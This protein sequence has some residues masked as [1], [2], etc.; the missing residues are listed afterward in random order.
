[1]ENTSGGEGPSTDVE[2]WQQECD[3]LRKVTGWGLGGRK[4]GVLR[5]KH[6]F[7]VWGHLGFTAECFYFLR[8]YSCVLRVHLSYPSLGQADF[9]HLEYRQKT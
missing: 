6:T 4:D 9:T 8:S 2:T 7:S 1:M 5:N 3:S